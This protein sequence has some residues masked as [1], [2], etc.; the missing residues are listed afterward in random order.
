MNEMFE[1]ARLLPIQ[2]RHLD[3]ILMWRNQEHIRKLMKNSSLIT[4][5][6]HLHWFSSLSHSSNMISKL[7][8]V[9]D[10]PY[11]LVSFTKQDNITNTWEWGF[12]IGVSGAPKGTG[13]QMGYTALEFAFLEM[14]IE[15][16]LSSILQHNEKSLRFH[17]KF[18]FSYKNQESPIGLICMEISADEWETHK[19]SIKAS[20]IG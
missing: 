7:F 2:Q 8:Y 15:K 4:K 9:K 3:M 18:G 10:E 1:Q 19:D 17:Q 12:Y 14:K 6:E 5:E 16:V 11:G 20:W 13:T